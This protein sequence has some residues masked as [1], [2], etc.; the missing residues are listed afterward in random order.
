MEN[1]IEENTRSNWK[2]IQDWVYKYMVW[3]L[4]IGSLLL[5]LLGN[6]GVFNDR[7]NSLLEKTGFAIMSSGVFAAVLKSI[8]FT[9]IFKEEIES[10]MLGTRFIENRSSASQQKLWKA[11]SKAIYKK[12][13]PELNGLIEDRILATY[14]PIG[15]KH[16]LK[17][18]IVTI[19]ISNITEDFEIE[20]TQTCKYD[21]ILDKGI[22]E[23]QIVSNVT[24]SEQEGS[25]DF[26][27]KLL[28]FKVDGEDVEPIKSFPV[29]GNKNK[30]SLTV[31]LAGKKIFKIHSKYERKYSLKKENYK[32]FR[33]YSFT[34]G[35]E[36][37]ISYPKN[38][39]VSFFNVGNVNFFEPQHVD[40]E[41][42][43][44]RSH[45]DDVILP[46]QGFG[47]SFER[48]S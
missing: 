40:I 44:C 13:F 19:K 14:L 23:T 39:S 4:I 25:P 27:N 24:V 42:Q 9:G 1:I 15:H 41:N 43:I 17:N 34:K 11:I 16:Y 28:F 20:Y 45:K 21:V 36:V 8:Q 35:I 10:I 48:N 37:I 7:A 18:Y 29:S 3:I 2:K 32:L 33:M 12:K 47:M 46:Y 26:V 6:I 30:I 22:N 31:P 38:V 5:L